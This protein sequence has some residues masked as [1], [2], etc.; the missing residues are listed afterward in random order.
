MEREGRGGESDRDED[1][2]FG[3][4]EGPQAAKIGHRICCNQI[5]TLQQDKPVQLDISPVVLGGH[6][7]GDISILSTDPKRLHVGRSDKINKAEDPGGLPSDLHLIL[8]FL[9]L[10]NKL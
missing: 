10:I 4:Q 1:P 8:L 9:G 5:P 7:R 6:R 2:P 3:K